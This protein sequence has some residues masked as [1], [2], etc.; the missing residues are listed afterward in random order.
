[1]NRLF[2]RLRVLSDFSSGIAERARRER[3]CKSPPHEKGEMQRGEREILPRL[4][5]R[6]WGDFHASSRFARSTIPEEKWGLLV[7]QL[8]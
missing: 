7:V 4:A 5:F 1:M 2:D 6:A 3:A 8:F